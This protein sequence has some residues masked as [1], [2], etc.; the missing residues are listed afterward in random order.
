MSLKL[1]IGCLLLL[2][3]IPLTNGCGMQATER[4]GA[5]SMQQPTVP[6]AGITLVVDPS[7]GPAPLG[8]T[9]R[10]SSLPAGGCRNFRFDFGDGYGYATNMACVIA[11]VTPPAGQL[12]QGQRGAS[13][14][15]TTAARTVQSAIPTPPLIQGTPPPSGMGT[16]PVTVF[17]SIGSP[18]T[19]PHTYQNPGTYTVRFTLIRFDPANGQ[20]IVVGT[21]NEVRVTVR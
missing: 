12:G 5:Q 17:N 2:L 19:L 3:L 15:V 14:T 7:E 11:V 9:F 20:E 18:L 6:S 13:P 1:P 8:V 21:A 10:V 4:T 16:P